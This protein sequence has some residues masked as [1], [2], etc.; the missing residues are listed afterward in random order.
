M[1]LIR[2][3]SRKGFLIACLISSA[4]FFQTTSDAQEVSEE[5]LLAP[6]ENASEMVDRIVFRDE[7]TDQVLDLLERLTGRS[8]IRPQALPAATFTFNSQQPLT[9]EEAILALESMLSING[10]GVAPLGELFLKVVPRGELR[11]EAPEFLMESTLDLVPSGRNVSRMIYLEFL[12]IDE[13]QTQLNMMISSGSGSIIPF[14]KANALLITDT[15]ANLQAIEELLQEVDRPFSPQTETRFFPLKY[16]GAEELMAQVQALGGL[17]GVPE[18]SART[19]LVADQRSNQ[20]IVI[21]DRRQMD[22]FENLIEKLDVP[23]ELTTHNE[24]IFLKHANSVDVASILSQLAGGSSG[25]FSSSTGGSG[26]SGGLG[27]GSSRFGQGGTSSGRGGGFGTGNRGTSGGGFQS[28]GRG[29]SRGGSQ[30]PG[31]VRAQQATEGGAPAAP[32]AIP[33]IPGGPPAIDG[34]TMNELGAAIGESDFSETLS[35]MPDERTNAII[36]AGTRQDIKLITDLIEKIDIILAQ[37]RIEAFIVEV[38]LDKKSA[39]GIDSFGIQIQDG[40]VSGTV[41]GPG[42][43]GGGNV[44]R[45]D[46]GFVLGGN[47]DWAALLTTAESDSNIHVMS[48]PSIVTTHNTEARILVGEQRPIITGTVTSDFSTTSTR[49]Q[50]DYRDI[51][52]EIVVLPLIGSD[53]TIQLEIEQIV[54]DVIGEIRID[55]NDQPIIGK[56]EA[57]SFISVANG[58][59]VIL[60]GLQS[61]SVSEGE[62]RLGI[63]GQ[64]PILGNIFKRESNELV[65]RELLVFIRPIVLP[66]PAVAYRD[67]QEQIDK[68][69]RG[70]YLRHAL[71]PDVYPDPDAPGHSEEARAL[72]QQGLQREAEREAAEANLENQNEAEEPPFSPE[73]PVIEPESVVEPEPFVEPAPSPV[74]PEAESDDGAEP[75][76]DNGSRRDGPVLRRR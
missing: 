8:I 44:G 13:V 73:T 20:I 69:S 43:T 28:G 33:A 56:R 59:T 66:D 74:I 72:R 55:G 53:G 22:H 61:T 23:A 18:L 50:I 52:T 64:L 70:P 12:G 38:T 60:G 68:F 17:E 26:R 46:G 32:P 36:V 4:A 15:V 25:G 6:N 45:S 27:G 19:K 76:N 16:A 41:S 7:T 14:P 49:S 30:V 65:R 21:A 63:L 71:E 54:E 29:M 75:E 48:V 67:T 47:I 40:T 11:T 57:N 62:S 39:R 37:V 31:G 9:R 34:A 10:I 3:I 1:T 51:G 42:Y 5:S 58:E 24:V 2:S 35:I